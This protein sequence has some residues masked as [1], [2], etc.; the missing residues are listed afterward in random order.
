MISFTEEINREWI[1]LIPLT[2]FLAILPRFT[3]SPIQ[4]GLRA[5]ILAIP[6]DLNT[7][8]RSL[9]GWFSFVF[10]I[11]VQITPLTVWSLWWSW[12]PLPPHSCHPSIHPPT[13]TSSVVTYYGSALTCLF[14]STSHIILFNTLCL[15]QRISPPV[16]SY[17][18]PTHI[19]TL[20]QNTGS[21]VMLEYWNSRLLLL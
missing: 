7:F 18:M 16:C 10:H 5:F 6:S 13:H 8:P 15:A 11:S 12:P 1:R 4:Y 20:C 17:S 19:S 2:S 3:I 21:H 14:H 9:P